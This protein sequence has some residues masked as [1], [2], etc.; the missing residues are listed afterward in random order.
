MRALI[1][2][3]V[4]ARRLPDVRFRTSPPDLVG[5][6]HSKIF[7]P[8]IEQLRHEISGSAS[9][10]VPLVSVRAGFSLCRGVAC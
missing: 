9:F 4:H 8:S 6:E 1:Y 3:R 10:L 2:P 7:A 5:A